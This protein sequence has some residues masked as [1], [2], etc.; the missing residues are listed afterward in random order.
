MPD[1]IHSG[2]GYHNYSG[3]NLP[4]FGGGVQLGI[5]NNPTVF[6]PTKVPVAD[7]QFTTLISNEETTYAAYKKGGM[8]Q[9]PAYLTARAA[10][11]AALDNTAVFVDNIANGDEKI[12]IMAGYKPT[13]STTGNPVKP[14]APQTITIT[15][16]V[17]TGELN[18]EC[19]SFGIEH[20]YGCIVSAGV[21]LPAGITITAT[22]QLIIPAGQTNVIIHDVTV[23]R[24]KQFTGLTKGVDY[25][26]YFYVSNTEGV[27]PLSV[28]V[29]KMSQ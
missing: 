12:I 13:N 8:A 28:A 4:V 10:L 7:T 20:I 5:K 11:M 29:S 17:S 2:L 24:K 23:Q 27:S 1:R 25:Y 14:T 15:N 3:S 6:D 26:F 18:A 19:E 16:G 9:K 22:G 21:P